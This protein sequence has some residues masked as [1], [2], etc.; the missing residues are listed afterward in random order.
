M[1][2]PFT[3][4]CSLGWLL[5]R[6]AESDASELVGWSYSSSRRCIDLEGFVN[7]LLAAWDAESAFPVFR[8]S[9]TM[10]PQAGWMDGWMD[11]KKTTRGC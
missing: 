4:G 10:A 8:E 9:F 5:L 3:N 7:G 2:S 6:R 1:A 11:P